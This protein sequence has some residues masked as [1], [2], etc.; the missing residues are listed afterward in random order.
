MT[1]TTGTAPFGET[2]LAEPPVRGRPLTATATATELMNRIYRRQRH[3]YDI[4][5]KWFLLG[6]DRLID[7]LRPGPGAAV[8]E[9]GCGTGRNLIVAALR[10]PNA[11]FFG[12]DVSTHMLTSAIEAIG[13]AGLSGRVRV[14]HAD[15]TAFDPGMLFGTPRFERIMISYSLSMMP[16]WHAALD[17]ALSQLTRGGSLHVVD[18][19]GQERLPRWFRTVLRIWLARF[20]VRPLDVLEERLAYLAARAGATLAVERP[21][22][23]YAQYAVVKASG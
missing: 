8:L 6:R 20:H 11:R 18:F 23:G 19:G 10:Y 7:D 2:T 9:I 15:A 12:V 14:A 13:Q 16:G 1:T 21:Y 22:R 5:R 4:T 3:I 17:L